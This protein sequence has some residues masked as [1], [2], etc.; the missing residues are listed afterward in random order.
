MEM[1]QNDFAHVAQSDAKFAQ[2]WSQLLF[3]LNVEADR[4]LEIWVPP[5]QRQQMLGRSGIDADHPLGMVDDPRVSRQPIGP[6]GLDQWSRE[7]RQTMP[8][9]RDLCPLD[10][11]ATGLH[12]VNFHLRR[13]QRKGCRKCAM[14]RRYHGACGQG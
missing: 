6:L 5:R 3:A 14:S 12:S 11:N 10:S 7:A 8:C 4:K 1:G 2:L 13:S 9:R